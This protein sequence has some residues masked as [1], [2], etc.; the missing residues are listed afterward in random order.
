MD[1]LI[2]K[3]KHQMPK[4]WKIIKKEEYAN[5]GVYQTNDYEVL[6]AL[7]TGDRVVSVNAYPE[8][9]NFIEEYD[10]EIKE[11]LKEIEGKDWQK[12]S[13]YNPIIYKYLKINNKRIYVSIFEVAQV[14]GFVSVQIFHDDKHTLGFFFSAKKEEVENLESFFKTNVIA[15]N[16]IKFIM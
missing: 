13:F 2:E 11:T 10:Q 3:I 9:E 4:S 16:V 8:T 14:P 6:L 1:F 5:K 7:E 12:I 15:K